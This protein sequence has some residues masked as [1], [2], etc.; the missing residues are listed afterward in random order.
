MTIKF[1][2]APS[3]TLLLFATLIGCASPRAATA[4]DAQVRLTDDGRIYVG[5]T[6]TGLTK[7]TAQLKALGVKSET[8]IKV[9]IPHNTSS[10]AI[11]AIGRELASSGYPRFVFSKPRRASAEKGAD[12][13]LLHLAP[14]KSSPG[15]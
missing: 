6:Y 15:R 10:N 13:L 7:L 2:L 1:F 9:E 5:K 14:E 4:N 12:P 11:I 3:L 8:R